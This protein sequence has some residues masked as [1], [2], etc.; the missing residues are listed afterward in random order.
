MLPVLPLLGRKRSSR[1]AWH[2]RYDL[3]WRNL[4]WKNPGILFLSFPFQILL[5]FWLLIVTELIFSENNAE[6]TYIEL[7]NILLFYIHPWRCFL[8]IHSFIHLMTILSARYSIG[9]RTGCWGFCDQFSLSGFIR[10]SEAQTG[11]RRKWTQK[12]LIPSLPNLRVTGTI[13]LSESLPQLAAWCKIFLYGF[14]IFFL[15]NKFTFC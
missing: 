7:A 5:P 10:K 2:P 9:L 11:Q 1:T 8:N 13:N 12:G 3:G 15:R 6:Q 14:L 4:V